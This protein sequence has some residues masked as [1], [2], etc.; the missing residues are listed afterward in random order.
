[1]PTIELDRHFSGLLMADCVSLQLNMWPRPQ[2]KTFVYIYPGLKQWQGVDMS[3]VKVMKALRDLTSV[4]PSQELRSSRA[5]RKNAG[6]QWFFTRQMGSIKRH[7]V[8]KMSSGDERR[9]PVLLISLM[10]PRCSPLFQLFNIF[11]PSMREATQ[12]L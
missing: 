4:T 9:Y 3:R 2:P 11:P 8:S 6:H 7:Y 1:M 10:S 12:N 5:V